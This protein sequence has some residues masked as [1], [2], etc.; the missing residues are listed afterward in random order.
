MLSSLPT[1]IY[2]ETTELAAGSVAKETIVKPVLYNL[3]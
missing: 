1:K 3:Y 2:A